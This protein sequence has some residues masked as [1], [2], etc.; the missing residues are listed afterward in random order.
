M[1]HA[2]NHG[3]LQLVLEQQKL[4]AFI[5]NEG[6]LLVRRKDYIDVFIEDQPFN[7]VEVLFNLKTQVKNI[8]LKWFFFQ[9]CYLSCD[10]FRGSSYE[11]GEGRYL[12]RRGRMLLRK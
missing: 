6:W 5:I 9:S 10:D 11:C 1:S 3:T 8:A 7:S 12:T 4:V 2:F